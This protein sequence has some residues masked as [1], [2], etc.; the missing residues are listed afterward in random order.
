MITD[1][2]SRHDA[3]WHYVNRKPDGIKVVVDFE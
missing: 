3:P 2:V 1:R